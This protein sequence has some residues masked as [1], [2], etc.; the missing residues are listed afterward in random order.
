MASTTNGKIPAAE[1]K[2][3]DMSKKE[4]EEDED[5]EDLDDLDGESPS[6]IY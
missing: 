2:A 5:E 4:E 1:E 6:S 3:V